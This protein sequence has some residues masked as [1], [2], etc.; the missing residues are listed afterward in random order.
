MG[1]LILS[2]ARGQRFHGVKCTTN[3]SSAYGLQVLRFRFNIWTTSASTKNAVTRHQS[4]PLKA[5]QICRTRALRTRNTAHA[6]A[7]C[8]RRLLKCRQSSTP[9]QS[10]SRTPRHTTSR[11]FGSLAQSSCDARTLF[12]PSQGPPK[13]TPAS[14]TDP[15]ES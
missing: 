6:L 1:L 14:Q 5:E 15:G 4:H 10:P 9:S 3:S 7:Q 13:R 8:R 11:I 12:T 2:S